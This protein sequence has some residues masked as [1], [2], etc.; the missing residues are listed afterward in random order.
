MKWPWIVLVAGCG[1]YD[2]DWSGKPLEP[3]QVEIEGVKLTIS[4]PKGL[5]RDSDEK[6]GTWNVTKVEGDHVPKIF[7]RTDPITHD[8]V[9]DFARWVIF[10]K[11][12]M[13]LVRKET[14]ADGF[15]IT[16]APKNK[17]RIEAI[18]YKRIGDKAFQCTAVQVGDGEVPSFEKTR[19][20]LEKICDSIVAN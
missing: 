6:P 18:T 16:D 15:A 20:M 9:D 12:K 8:D 1:G 11:E 7:L 5:P 10:N 19:A 17:H 14:R 4:V 13:N 3:T 2:K